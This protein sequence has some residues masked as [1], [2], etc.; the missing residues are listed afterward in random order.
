MSKALETHN[1]SNDEWAI[2]E[3]VFRDYRFSDRFLRVIDRLRAKRN[4]AL[5]ATVLF[6]FM[7]GFTF[8]GRELMNGHLRKAK[9]PF[10]IVRASK[11]TS[12]ED[13]TLQI[14]RWRE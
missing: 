6:D 10:R 5:P 3:S 2:L 9:V 12:G 7:D 14:V 4:E 13:P 8:T 1:L 11:Y